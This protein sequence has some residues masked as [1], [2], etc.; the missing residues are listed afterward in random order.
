MQKP[1][2]ITIKQIWR[3]IA[4]SIKKEWKYIP[5]FFVFAA[6]MTAISVSEPY[7]Y[8][9]IIDIVVSGAGTGSLAE[10]LNRVFPFL[11]A[12][13]G[14]LIGEL[15]TSA[16]FVY[17]VWLFGNI[18]QGDLLNRLYQHILRLDLSAFEKQKSGEVSQRYLSAW[19]A[20]WMTASFIT[21]DALEATFRFIFGVAL[22]LFLSHPR[23]SS[24]PAIRSFC[25][26]FQ[27][28]HFKRRSGCL[29][30]V[31]GKIERLYNRHLCQY[32]NGEKLFSRESKR[33]VATPELFGSC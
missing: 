26:L 4:P 32:Q 14:V 30:Y 9:R 21:K 25:C 3:M 13:G 20:F 16:V 2:D 1:E 6:L 18:W 5:L 29:Q 33:E 27:L 10:V 17:T 19:H 7:I 28:S 12:W 22:G 8:G 23:D 15:I 24:D 31:L 11:A